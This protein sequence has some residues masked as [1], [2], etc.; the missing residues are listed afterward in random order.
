[1]EPS[2]IPEHI[3]NIHEDTEK[4]KE[5][6]LHERKIRTEEYHEMMHMRMDKEVQ[7]ILRGIQDKNSS[8]S[9]EIKQKVDNGETKLYIK[10]KI[11]V[12]GI[13]SGW[14]NN[15]KYKQKVLLNF[16]EMLNAVLINTN[17]RALQSH[18]R[19]DYDEMVEYYW[20]RTV[21][22][23]LS[24]PTFLCCGPCILDHML[25][26]CGTYFEYYVCLDWTYVI[27]EN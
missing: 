15:E 23:L 24:C 22:I 9:K 25:G 6:V 21:L 26:T 1:M 13:P 12:S 20:Y 8:L 18:S 14:V 19:Y 4:G 27:P 3:Q 5:R 16:V 10:G 17:I 11:P 2:E 7:R